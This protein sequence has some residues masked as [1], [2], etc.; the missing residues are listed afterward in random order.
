M[1]GGM[2]CLLYDRHRSRHRFVVF[3]GN[4]WLEHPTLMPAIIF[5][6]VTAGAPMFIMQPAFGLGVAASKTSKSMQAGLRSLTNHTVFGIGLY[7]FGLL[8]SRSLQV[9]A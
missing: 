2:D 1:H 3:M 5:G 4:N 9:V 7:L 8:V 6:I